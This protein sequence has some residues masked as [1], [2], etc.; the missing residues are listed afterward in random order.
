MPLEVLP[1]Q[2]AALWLVQRPDAPLQ[3]GGLALFEGAPLRDGRGALRLEELRARVAAG[4]CTTPRFRQRLRSLPLH[5]GA[6][7]VDDEDFDVTRHVRAEAL[8]PPGDD[9]G[10]RR[11][12]ARIL[13]QPLDPDRP[14]W[15]VR[16][17]DGLSGDRV[18][19]V[20]KANHSLVDGTALVDLVGRFLDRAP[21]V[22]PVDGVPLGEAPPAGGPSR[23]QASWPD[24]APG[25]LPLVVTEV[26][27]RAGQVAEGLGQ[28][29]GL[30]ADPRALTGVAR[31]VRDAVLDAVGGAVRGREGGGG[32]PPVTGRVGSRRDVAWTT[33]SLAEVRRVAHAASVTVNDVVLTLAT[34]ALSG[35]LEAHPGDSPTRD[36]RALVPVSVHGEAPGDEVGN[37]FSVVAAALPVGVDDPHERLRRLHEELARRKLGAGSSMGARVY[38]VAGLV[39]PPLLRV[40]ARAALDRQGVVDL[41]VTNLVGPAVPRHLLG[42]RMLEVQPLVTGTG[43]IALIIGVLSYDG[44][45]G[46]CATVDADVIADPEVVVAGFPRGLAELLRTSGG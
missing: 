18:A 25:G 22:A 26:R 37:R 16:M 34:E 46:V 41:A 14:L 27:A 4:L 5:Q 31:T 32:R 10:L 24:P 9:D 30:L 15:E 23:D 11:W 43:N 28:V 36:P 1:A 29:A 42:A 44:Q 39:P 3:I 2:D 35:Y 40:A 13:E 20:V 17:L 38:G 7:W 21:E 33:L 6:A 45:L 8:D 12:V 19:M